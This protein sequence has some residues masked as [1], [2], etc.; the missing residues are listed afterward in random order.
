MSRGHRHDGALA[1]GAALD[2]LAP[3]EAARWAGIRDTCPV[4]RGLEAEFDAVLGEL[5]LATPQ[6][7]PPPGGLAGIRA[8]IRAEDGRAGA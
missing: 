8:A 4:C 6:Q 1:A 5:A 7:V 3:P 2:D